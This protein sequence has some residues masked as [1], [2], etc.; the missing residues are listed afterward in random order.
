[1][2]LRHRDWDAH[3]KLDEGMTVADFIK[4]IVLINKD[5]NKKYYKIST[6]ET[7]DN[8]QNLIIYCQYNKVKSHHSTGI[9]FDYKQLLNEKIKPYYEE[10]TIRTVDIISF[11]NDFEKE[12][13]YKS[14]GGIKNI[15]NN[16]IEY[17]ELKNELDKYKKNNEE[18]QEQIKWLEYRLDNNI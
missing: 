18:F 12:E 7:F 8:K 9:Y 11:T 15:L 3:K 1:M 14:E 2:I 13:Q 17:Y 16:D 5:K 10:R 4:Q 6:I